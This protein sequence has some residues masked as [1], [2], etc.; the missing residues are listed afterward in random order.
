MLV[1]RIVSFLL[2]ACLAGTTFSF[3]AMRENALS[4]VTVPVMEPVPATEATEL[5]TTQAT[6]PETTTVPATEPAPQP[7]K[8]SYSGNKI[9]DDPKYI[10]SEKEIIEDDPQYE[11]P[12]STEPPVVDTLPDVDLP[13]VGGGTPLPTTSPATEAPATQPVSQPPASSTSPSSPDPSEPSSP[14]ATEPMP[15]IHGW[16]TDANGDM[17]LYQNGKPVTGLQT[18][19]GFRY[20]FD[21]SGKLISQVGIDVSYHQGTIDWNAVK[22]A[23]VQF[24]FIRVGYRGWGSAGNLRIDPKFVENI[25]GAQSAGIECGVYF[26]SQAITRQEAVEEAAFVLEAIKGYKLTYPVVFDTEQ[27][28]NAG[29]RTNLANLSDADRTNF[30]IDFCNTIKNA[31]YYPAIYASK[32]WMLDEMEP[33]RL[34]GYDFWLAHYT[35]Q[36]DYPR[37]YKVWQY[38]KQGRVS[39]ISTDVDLNIGYFDYPSFMRKNGWN[40]L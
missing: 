27:D 4:S 32:S 37:A 17:F 13:P 1:K 6:E 24:A 36:T 30:C 7:V 16:F 29:A 2:V 10:P 33:D 19:Q 15:P 28:A 3:G 9:T 23:G 21:S 31:G 26:Y 12:K 22:R 39:G 14:P 20:S 34:S 18:I 5:E 35:Q 38:S 25:R 11:S 8:I 40:H